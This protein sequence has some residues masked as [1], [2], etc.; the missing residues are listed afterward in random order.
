VSIVQSR[1]ERLSKDIKHETSLAEGK[2]E[3]PG[4]LIH[5][6]ML[7]AQRRKLLG[8]LAIMRQ[9]QRKQRDGAKKAAGSAWT[10]VV[11]GAEIVCATLSG[12]GLLAADRT[13]AR[14][15]GR[16]RGGVK[17]GATSEEAE[18]A[19][20]GCAVPLFDLIIVDEAAQATEAATLV[21]LRWLRPGGAAAFVG[22]PQQ[23]AATV[24]S[25]GSAKRSIEQSLFERLQ[26][27]G[28]RTH[29]LSVQYRMHPEIRQFPSDA[30]YDGKLVDGN[31]VPHG[32]LANLGAYVAFDV[33]EGYEQ[34]GRFS[35]QSLSNAAEASLAAVLYTKLLSRADVT[36]RVT[37][38]VVTPYKDQ[39]AQL[40]RVFEPLIKG[41]P[42]AH[43]TPVE[44]ATVDGVQGREFDVVIFSCV[45]AIQGM[46]AASVDLT[47]EFEYMN[48][49]E[50]AAHSRRMIGFLSDRRRLN[51][52]LTRPKRALFV[53]GHAATLR[54]ADEIWSM[55]WGDAER[56]GVAI[57][58]LRPYGLHNFDRWERVKYVPSDE[59]KVEEKLQGMAPDVIKP[60]DVV[61]DSRDAVVDLTLDDDAVPVY[62][63]REP[64]RHPAMSARPT[65]K[66]V[67]RRADVGN[68]PSW[69]HEPLK[70]KKPKVES[71]G[72]GRVRPVQALQTV[73]KSRSTGKTTT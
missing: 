55:F 46:D 41:R 15:G 40:K 52:A 60:A 25:R 26:D 72:A 4:Q 16:G 12:A 9:K 38:G 59:V 13:G 50:A 20:V 36:Q 28:A 66:P 68:T 6:Q 57:R 42:E 67:K 44:F 53:L 8:E 47:D 31:V 22:D 1:L 70:P 18:A 35:G 65:S 11:G 34:R 71:T 61:K 62:S 32:S 54:R 43:V 7:Q 58:A 49:A 51:V 63:A 2:E 23:L 21:P 10:R 33:A 45:R 48:D 73:P 27:A 5:L 30:F 56:R 69:L 17:Q 19:M 29:L 64:P 39:I 14:A 3:N 24:L 37:V